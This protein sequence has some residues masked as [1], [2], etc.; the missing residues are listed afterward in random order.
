MVIIIGYCK[1]YRSFRKSEKRIKI[2]YQVF[3]SLKSNEDYAGF[4]HHCMPFHICKS[5]RIAQVHVIVVIN[6]KLMKLN[7]LLLEVSL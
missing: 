5:I 7:Y 4:C 6:L 2:L 1:V 3:L